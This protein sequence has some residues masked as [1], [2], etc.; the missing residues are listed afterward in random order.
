MVGKG[1]SLLCIGLGC[2]LLVFPFLLLSLHEILFNECVA[3]AIA[4][5]VAVG[6]IKMY[7]S[8]IR[9]FS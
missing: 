9:R 3:V 8:T 6:I 4:T 2:L 1:H 5:V 7:P